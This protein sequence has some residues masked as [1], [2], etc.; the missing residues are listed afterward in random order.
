[1]TNAAPLTI[2]EFAALE[3]ALM[4]TARGRAFL[5]EHARRDRLVA[6]VTVTESLAS[7]KNLLTQQGNTDDVSLFRREIENMAASI[8]HTRREIAAIKPPDDSGNNRIMAAT[9]ELDAIVTATERATNDILGAAERIQ[10][11]ASQLPA[12]GVDPATA[13]EIEE[14]ATTIFMACAFQDITGQRTTKVVN[15]LRYLEQR[16]NSMMDI[17]GSRRR[18][19]SGA[20]RHARRPAPRLPSPQWPAARRSWHEPERH[21]RHAEGRT[22]R[23]PGARRR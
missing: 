19:G 18:E 13:S 20:D 11:M 1:M 3:E 6:M 10:D 9:E 14:L 4:V 21:R 22:G 5:G 15:V 12:Q 2:A 8:Q 17:W 23:C 16:V 7:F